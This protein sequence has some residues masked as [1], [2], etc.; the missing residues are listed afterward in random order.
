MYHRI[1][2]DENGNT[3]QEFDDK[4]IEY[5]IRGLEK[6]RGMELGGQLETPSLE[7]DKEGVPETFQQFI[8]RRVETNE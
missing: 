8:I 3:V 2:E 6:L 5:F 4:A 7:F 1:F